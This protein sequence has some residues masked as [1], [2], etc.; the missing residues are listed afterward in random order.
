MLFCFIFIL[1][2][3][4]AYS[5]RRF[6]NPLDGIRRGKEDECSFIEATIPMHLNI[7]NKKQFMSFKNSIVFSRKWHSIG[8]GKGVYDLNQSDLVFSPPVKMFCC[9]SAF[10]LRRIKV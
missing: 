5:N 6:L 1:L 7:H 9:P 2:I 8:M 10:V 4:S 3:V